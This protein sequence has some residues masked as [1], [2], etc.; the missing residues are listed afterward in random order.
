DSVRECEVSLE[1]V[2]TGY[3]DTMDPLCGVPPCPNNYAWDYGSKMCISCQTGVAPPKVVGGDAQYKRTLR[4]LDSVGVHHLQN[5]AG[6]TEP[7]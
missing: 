7:G 3:F 6:L 4:A 1:K 2:A 5:F